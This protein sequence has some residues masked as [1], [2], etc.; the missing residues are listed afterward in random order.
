MSEQQRHIE[1]GAARTGGSAGEIRG[2]RRRVLLRVR[3]VSPLHAA[4]AVVTQAE[5]AVLTTAA[6]SAGSAS[7]K[8]GWAAR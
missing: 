1:Q 3:M 5:A 8:L 7:S 6:A 2:D 4:C